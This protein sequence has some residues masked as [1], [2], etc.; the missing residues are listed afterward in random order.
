MAVMAVREEPWTW[1]ARYLAAM[2]VHRHGGRK[3]KEEKKKEV[4]E[5]G[6]ALCER[7]FAVNGS[8]GCD[9]V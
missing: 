9:V 6:A 5:R 1:L 7:G 8:T 4:K 2:G 3:R